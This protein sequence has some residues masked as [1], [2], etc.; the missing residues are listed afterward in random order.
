[1]VILMITAVIFVFSVVLHE[2]AHGWV[3]SQ[4]G[5]STAKDEGRLTFNPVPHIDLWGSIILPAMCI[6]GNS[7]IVLGWAKPVPVTTYYLNSYRL[8]PITLS[9][10]LCVAGC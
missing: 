4:F 3:A 1:M 7:S 5:D 2:V 9:G 6:L 8:G 10:P